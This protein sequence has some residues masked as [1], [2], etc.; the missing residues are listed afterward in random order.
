WADGA[1]D[2]GLPLPTLTAATA[3]VGH[4]DVVGAGETGLPVGLAVVH[5]DGDAVATTVGLLGTAL[6]RAYASLGTSA[7]VAVATAEPLAA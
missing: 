3:I 7:W 1:R 6:G 4:L 5:D 2:A